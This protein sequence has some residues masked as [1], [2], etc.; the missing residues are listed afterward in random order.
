MFSKGILRRDFLRLCLETAA[1]LCCRLTPFQ[2]AAVVKLVAE[3][4][5]HVTGRKAPVTAAVGDGG[6]DVAMLLQAN[7]GIG[8]YGNEGRQAV[9]A[10]DYAVPLF[11]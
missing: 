10:A 3:G 11:K 9:C 8:I 4:M 6:N 2:K 5:K 7:V 1:V